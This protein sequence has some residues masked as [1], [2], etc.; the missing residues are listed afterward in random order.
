MKKRRYNKSLA[1][2]C[3]FLFSVGNAG[4]WTIE[5]S[6]DDEIVES[7]CNNW[8]SSQSVVSI[9]E[10]AS[11]TKSCKQNVIAGTTGFGRWGGDYIF[12]F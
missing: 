10:F 4:A 8:G 7:R 1:I 6:Y 11:G 9:D 5:Q 2:G 3:L 12:P